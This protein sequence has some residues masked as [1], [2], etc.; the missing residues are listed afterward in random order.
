MKA[1]AP[2]VAE[3]AAYAGRYFS[4]ELETFYEIRVKDGKLVV[5]HRRMEAATLQPG[6]KESFTGTGA[7]ANVTFAFERDRSGQVIAFY[8]GNGRS[9]DIRFGRVR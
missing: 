2:T 7:A 8:A 1:W 5:T 3:L 6:V 9:R 4:E